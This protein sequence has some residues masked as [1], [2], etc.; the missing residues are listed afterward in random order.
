[1]QKNWAE[2][3][4]EKTGGIVMEKLLLRIEKPNWQNTPL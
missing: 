3:E 4:K 2:L 1:M